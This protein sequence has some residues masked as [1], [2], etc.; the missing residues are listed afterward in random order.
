MSTAAGAV[1]P[2]ARGR[3]DTKQLFRSVILAALWGGFASWCWIVLRG[4]AVIE[5]ISTAEGL[6]TVLGAYLVALAVWICVNSFISRVRG[7]VHAEVFEEPAFTKDYFGRAVAL[8][9]GASFSD[10]HLVLD[11]KDGKKIYRAPQTEEETQIA[12]ASSLKELAAAAGGYRAAAPSRERP[13]EGLNV[14]DL[15]GH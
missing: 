2:R 9:K 7:V 8:E 3:V 11:Y 14:R 4:P 10:Q 1:S 15:S 13:P 6:A 5:I 12:A